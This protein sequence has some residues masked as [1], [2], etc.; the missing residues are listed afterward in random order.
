MKIAFFTD[1]YFPQLNGVTISV[2]NYA[3]ALREKGHT[4]YIFA[5][6]IKG[7]KDTEKDVYRLPSVKVLSSEPEVMFPIGVSFRGMR[8]LLKMDFDIVHAHGN[9][10]FS[11][12]GQ[13]VARIQK[14]PFIITFH[15]LHTEYTHYFF[16]GKVI[17]PGMV[18]RGFRIWARISDGI[19]AP[20]EKMR[21]KLIEFGCKKEIVIMPNFIDLSPFMHA[22]E[23]YLHKLLD[24][25]ADVP[26]LLTVGRLGKEKNFSFLIDVFAA[27]AQKE[28]K[29]HFV[30][31]GQGPEKEALQKQAMDRGVADRVHFTGRIAEQDMPHVYH[32]GAIFLFAS[33]TETQGICVLEAAAAGV[34]LIIGKDAAFDLILQ[35][36]EDGF[37]LP[38]EKEL[39]VQKIQEVLG[40]TSL[41]L[42]L[43][44][45]AA[46]LAQEQSDGT[47]HVDRLLA[48][49]GALQA[50][51]APHVKPFYQMGRVA[52]KGVRGVRKAGRLTRS[53]FSHIV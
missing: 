26:L 6:K 14:I 20:S 28:K 4:V 46:S 16:K 25:S 40:N 19:I 30:I 37:A 32:D 9:G 11:L 15:T 53:V 22:K 18:E 39:F 42:R 43:G 51:Y 21:Q 27:L 35:N 33:T 23:G 49:Y 44:H 47:M 17:K 38:F 2:A 29:S 36:G 52:R 1:T 50:V 45:K 24:L 13:R 12:L 10:A 34:P 3:K 48:Y 5:P 41:R 7:Y 31:V 8:Q